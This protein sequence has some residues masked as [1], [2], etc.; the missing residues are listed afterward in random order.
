MKAAENGHA[1]CVRVLIE[2]GAQANMKNIVS[3]FLFYLN[4]R[5]N[6]SL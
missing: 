5:Y 4:V 3:T 2:R 6:V 1:E